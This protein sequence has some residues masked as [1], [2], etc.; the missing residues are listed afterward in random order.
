MNIILRQTLV[1]FTVTLNLPH[2]PHKAIL[3]VR[4]LQFAEVK[5]NRTAATANCVLRPPVIIMKTLSLDTV[6]SSENILQ[7][8]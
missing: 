2:F 1:L 3:L 4:C 5:P 8:L 7:L 6:Q